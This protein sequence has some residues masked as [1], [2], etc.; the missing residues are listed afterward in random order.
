MSKYDVVIISKCLHIF[1]PLHT[2]NFKL[3]FEVK[4]GKLQARLLMKM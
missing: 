2:D 1:T 3:I 4:E